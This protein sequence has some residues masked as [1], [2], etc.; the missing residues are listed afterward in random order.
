MNMIDKYGSKSSQYSRHKN[1]DFY[2]D[3]LDI[4]SHCQESRLARWR[5]HNLCEEKSKISQW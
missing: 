1:A 5:I 2:A 4:F 3:F